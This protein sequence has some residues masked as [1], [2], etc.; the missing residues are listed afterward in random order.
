[1]L[2]NFLIKASNLHPS[3]I[4]QVFLYSLLKEWGLDGFL[5]HT[6]KVERFYKERRDMFLNC[7]NKH[8][9]GLAVWNVPKAGIL[10]SHL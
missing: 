2:I 6:E 9:S 5:K 4:S 7:A 1:M 10:N 8:L 3:G